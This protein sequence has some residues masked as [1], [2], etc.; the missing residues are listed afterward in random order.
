[1]TVDVSSE[2]EKL[3]RVPGIYF[4]DTICGRM[5]TI[6]GTGL[7][8]WEI[9]KPYREFGDDWQELVDLFDWLSVEQL[10]AALNYY[11]AF[12]DEVDARIS[13]EGRYTPEE[14]YQMYPFMRPRDA[15]GT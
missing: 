15:A 2:A 8:V 10:R 12:P 11:E 3:R 1:M 13:L 6:E 4:A 14:V 7:G 5:A 9:V